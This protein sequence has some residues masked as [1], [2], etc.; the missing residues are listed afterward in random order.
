MNLRGF[1]GGAVGQPNKGDRNR[2]RAEIAHDERAFAIRIAPVR[3]E[4]PEWIGE[5]AAGEA[6]E[7]VAEFGGGVGERRFVVRRRHAC[8]AAR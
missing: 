7:A 1:G 3:T 4:N 2:F 6:V 5:F 8:W